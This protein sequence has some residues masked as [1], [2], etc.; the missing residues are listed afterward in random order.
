M[1]PFFVAAFQPVRNLSVVL[2]PLQQQ[3][4]FFLHTPRV[5]VQIL[6]AATCPF[7]KIPQRI[8]ISKY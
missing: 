4:T 1:V 3:Q 2:I 8:K 6:H 7:E 5:I